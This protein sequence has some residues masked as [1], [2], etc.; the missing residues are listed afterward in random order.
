MCSHVIMQLATSPNMTMAI[1]KHSAQHAITR[2]V[3]GSW[4][5]TEL[6]DAKTTAEV[7]INKN[8][9][10]S[11]APEPR[12]EPQTQQQVNKSDA[13]QKRRPATQASTA[14]KGAAGT[15]QPRIQHLQ[16]LASDRLP[17]GPVNPA[18]E[19]GD[20]RFRFRR[21]EAEIAELQGALET[22]TNTIANKSKKIF[23]LNEEVKALRQRL[24]SRSGVGYSFPEGGGLR[25]TA[26][27]MSN[28]SR[29]SH[30]NSG[31]SA[32]QRS[33]LASA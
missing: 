18:A 22:A 28:S 23:D 12:A 3:G 8:L 24:Q 6:L 11:I 10:Y 31:S 29:S 25:R 33:P 15:A 4:D 32:R 16:S 27:T 13:V 19:V 2:D 14:Q 30:S 5:I 26:S 17:N 1:C 20:L 7:K 9:K 21:A